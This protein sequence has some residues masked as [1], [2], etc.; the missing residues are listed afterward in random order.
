MDFD[1]KNPIIL[2]IVQVNCLSGLQSAALATHTD[3]LWDRPQLSSFSVVLLAGLFRRSA[4]LALY[5]KSSAVSS[6]VLQFLVAF[7]AS[8]RRFS[9]RSL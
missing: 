5:L 8:Q 9:L 7:Q 1:A 6:S 3:R 4:S 2:F